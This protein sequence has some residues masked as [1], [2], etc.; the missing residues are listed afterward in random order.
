MNIGK[1][2]EVFKNCVFDYETEDQDSSTTESQL[3]KHFTLRFN[4][5][6]PRVPP[7]VLLLGPPGS[8]KY[9]QAHLLAQTF[10]MVHVSVRDLLKEEL[11]KNPALGPALSMYL[12]NN[13]NMPE[14]LV[15]Q[16]VQ[17]RLKQSDCSMYG[18]VLEGFPVTLGQLNLLQAMK[19][20][21]NVVIQVN[22]RK[23][24]AEARYSK[25]K[26]DPITGQVYNLGLTLVDNDVRDRLK[27]AGHTHEFVTNGFAQW[28]E[29]LV[30]LEDYFGEAISQVNG[31]S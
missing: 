27:P 14:M 15:N 6:S 1:V 17:F 16:L 4:V 25:K 8:G 5:T 29:N 11:K 7:K 2:K 26:V 10:G 9:T 20:T 22:Q 21:P 30:H 31:T 28:D 13:S 23:D 19:V 3:R 18:W 12:N 24:D